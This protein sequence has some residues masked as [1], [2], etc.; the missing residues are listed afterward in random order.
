MDPTYGLLGKL[1]AKPGQRAALI[2]LLLEAATHLHDAP[3]CRHWIVHEP[4]DDPDAVWITELWQTR[5]DHDASLANPQI[6][7][8]IARAMPLLAGPPQGG[9]ETIPRG[10]VGS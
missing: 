1:V 3:G 5:Q 8:I 4:T 9:V 6:R 2:D 7:A 10:G